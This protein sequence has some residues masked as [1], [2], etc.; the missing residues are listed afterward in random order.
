M[1]GV[2]ASVRVIDCGQYITSSID[3]LYLPGQ[4]TRILFQNQA[5]KYLPDDVHHHGFSVH[6]HVSVAVQTLDR[7]GLEHGMA[8][9]GLVLAVCGLQAELGA[10]GPVAQVARAVERRKPLTACCPA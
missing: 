2:L 6:Q 5:P 10:E 8:A 3:A 4:W 9:A 7:F 1:T